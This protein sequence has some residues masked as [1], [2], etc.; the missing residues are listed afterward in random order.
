MVYLS[1]TIWIYG[2]YCQWSLV[3]D[4]YSD[5]IHLQEDRLYKA[6]EEISDVFNLGNETY[7]IGDINLNTLAF[8]K[9]YDE[10]TSH[11][12]KFTSMYESFKKY[13]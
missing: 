10:K 13:D 3:N 1:K 12:M 5:K 11:E 2:L 6:I 7:L 9:S 4:K 8:N